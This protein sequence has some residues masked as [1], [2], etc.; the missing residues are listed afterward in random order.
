MKTNTGTNHESRLVFN[1]ETEKD[2]NCFGKSLNDNCL[3]ND[4]LKVI[5]KEV[6][7]NLLS[8]S[9]IPREFES[10]NEMNIIEVK[11]TRKKK[12]FEDFHTGSDL[13]QGSEKKF[14][15][16]KIKKS[17][18]LEIVAPIGQQEKENLVSE[19]LK[20]DSS[21]KII[22]NEPIGMSSS[23]DSAKTSQENYK[24]NI[25]TNK[26][27]DKKCHISLK[28][29]QK[30][31]TSKEK[32][33]LDLSLSQTGISKKRKLT[34]IKPI[35]SNS[36][37]KKI[38]S[39]LSKT[40]PTLT[41]ALEITQVKLDPDLSDVWPNLKKDLYCC[42]CEGSEGTLITCNGSCFNSFHFDCLGVSCSKPNFTCDECL[43]NNHC[44]F[45][46]KSP[47]AVIKCSHNMCGRYYHQHCLLKI[48][49]IKSQF[50]E[51]TKAFSCPLHSCSFCSEK[52]NKS[53]LNKLIKC[54][55]CPTAYHQ[56][57][58]LV[59]G[60]TI[61]T[62]NNMICDC[63][64]QPQKNNTQH[65]GVNVTWCF[66]CSQGGSL[67][68]CDTCPASFH[69]ECYEDLNEVPENSWHCN[70]CLQR[71]KPRYN[72]I[73]WVKYGVYRYVLKYFER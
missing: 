8:A 27:S 25:Y 44:C 13:F 49:V 46:C 24:C 31:C 45:L 2:G 64:F 11:R 5:L 42:I 37:K 7:L 20:K 47:G 51:N 32:D 22:K 19:E 23:K 3:G 18:Q 50:Q 30:N 53:P 15:N 59:A 72:D 39:S 65:L 55:R 66:V 9:C 54:I 63:H 56:S 35:E 1:S 52:S 58:C 16:K 70:D 21:Y 36:K 57:S 14:K 40:V 38:D 43:T 60:C 26:T 6:P 73:V 71:K 33:N 17:E 4:S 68:C 62:N 41:S 69:V 10:D 28:N 29:I 67:V 12:I 61:I 48:P 34:S